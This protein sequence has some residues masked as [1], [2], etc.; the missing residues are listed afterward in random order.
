MSEHK[1]GTVTQLLDAVGRGDDNARSRLWTVLYDELHKLAQR[2]LAKEPNACELG[3]TSLI[4]EAFIRLTGGD[5]G[6]AN[7]RHFF[8]SAANVMRQILVDDARR[9]KRDKRG[10]GA[11]PV[12]LKYDPV[13][14]DRDPDEVVA[15]HEALERLAQIDPR[16][17][18]VVKYRYFA[19]LTGDET[20]SL[21]EV[22][23]RTVDT[24]WQFA[25]AWL[26]RELAKGDARE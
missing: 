5:A 18:E 20:A 19:G 7:R 24:D 14:E 26:H 9:R 4:H 22:S 1:P 6:F 10:G 16:K 25:K 13:G 23:A 17:A 11:V 3:T 2:R 15:V 21:L 8:A 12:S